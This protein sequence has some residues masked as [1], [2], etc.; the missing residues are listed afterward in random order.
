MCVSM[1]IYVYTYIERDR[2][3]EER[4]EEGREQGRKGECIQNLEHKRHLYVCDYFGYV[5]SL[6]LCL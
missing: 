5:H 4:K 6:K 2:R 3:E 1:C